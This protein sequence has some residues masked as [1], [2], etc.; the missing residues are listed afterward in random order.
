MYSFRILTVL[1]VV[2]LGV[3][4]ALPYPENVRDKRQLA[5]DDALQPLDVSFF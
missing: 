4:L 3:A 2:T 1:F 5:D